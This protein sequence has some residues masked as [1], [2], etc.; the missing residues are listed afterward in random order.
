[1]HLKITMVLVFLWPV[2]PRLL[3]D[4]VIINNV[5]IVSTT[6]AR[7]PQNRH[8]VLQDGIIKNSTMVQLC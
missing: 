2:S 7:I 1:M 6:E 3:A 8:V 5:N 4:T